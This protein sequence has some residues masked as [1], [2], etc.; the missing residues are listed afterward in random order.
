MR[1]FACGHEMEIAGNEPHETLP[2]F[3]YYTL[4]C[5][6]CAETERRLL[7]RGRASVTEILRWATASQEPLPKPQEKIGQ[8]WTDKESRVIN[9]NKLLADPKRF[10]DAFVRN[11]DQKK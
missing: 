7:P 2:Y 6:G 3:E 8:P 10:M 5:P 1:C 11:R 4:S 9:V